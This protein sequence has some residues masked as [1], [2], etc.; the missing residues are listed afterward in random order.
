[1]QLYHVSLITLFLFLFT[2]HGLHHMMNTE[3]L[4]FN[5]YIYTLLLDFFFAL[6]INSNVKFEQYAAKNS[7]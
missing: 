7:Y 5:S 4:K 3:N 6:S 2:D 1:M